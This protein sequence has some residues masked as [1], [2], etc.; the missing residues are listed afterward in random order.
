MVS[1]LDKSIF[2][3]YIIIMNKINGYFSGTFTEWLSIS[4]SNLKLEMFGWVRL[5]TIRHLPRWPHG[6]LS[7][8][9]THATGNNV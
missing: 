2:K 5:R 8:R 9:A 3:S 1:S 4:V 7:E 6:F